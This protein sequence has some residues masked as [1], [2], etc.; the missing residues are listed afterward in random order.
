MV[1]LAKDYPGNSGCFDITYEQVGL[2]SYR[3]L[4]TRAVTEILAERARASKLQ[5]EQDKIKRLASGA[6]PRPR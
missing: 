4:A 6:E 3:V 5:A 1:R 2:L